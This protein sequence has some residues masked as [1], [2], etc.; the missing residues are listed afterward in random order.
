MMRRLVL[1]SILVLITTS[2]VPV[3]LWSVGESI[4]KNESR[5]IAAWHLSPQNSLSGFYF[6]SEQDCLISGKNAIKI[7]DCSDKNGKPKWQTDSNWIVKE[8]FS[9]DF[10]HDGKNELVMLVW[11][12][13]KPWP[14]DSFLPHGGRIS[15]FQDSRGMSCHIIL[16]GWD[17]KEYRELWA[18]S[19]MI[20]PIF[21]IQAA[22]LDHDGNQELVAL[23][24]KYDSSNQTGN[25]TVWD[26]SG[27]GF[28]LRDRVKGLF[29]DYGIVSNDHN[30][31]IISN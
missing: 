13:Y 8:A 14:I 20:D 25:L 11:R 17:G 4:V 29:S 7:V 24:G 3:H 5:N 23:E 31:L 1:I 6:G 12:P 22:D 18:G 16:V 9:A 2:P 21:D 19:S 26:W 15:T 28:R 30:V 27:F 10:N